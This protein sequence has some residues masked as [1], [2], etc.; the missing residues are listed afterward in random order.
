MQLHLYSTAQAFLTATQT[1]LEAEE[2]AN[3]LMYGLALR[4]L[5]FPERFEPPPYLCA[6][7]EDG[8]P[9]VAALMTPPHNLVVFSTQRKPLAEAFDLV[10]QNLRRDDWSV[11]GVIGP[12]AA[13]LGFAQAWQHLTGQTYT[14]QMHARVYELRR[15]IPPPQPPG[16]MRLAVEEDL[17]L[18]AR[19]SQAFHEEALPDEPLSTPE[20][21]LE[22]AHQR[23]GDRS[24][25]LWQDSVPVALAGWTRPTP[26]GCSVGPVYT[27]PKYRGKGYASALT[28]GLSQLLLDQGKLFTAL[29][30]TL[31]NPTSNSIYQKI[32]YRPVTD[33]DLYCF[34]A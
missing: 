18:I 25:F 4:I 7:L 2:A 13:A 29:F 20:Q 33:F 3:G 14:L 5:K 9:V 11:P 32:G 17:D 23:I 34:S 31:A 16:S 21:Y 28:A 10:A 15:V 30:T 27:P 22:F 19:W 24:F 1:A 8:Q 6:V 26:H 12:N